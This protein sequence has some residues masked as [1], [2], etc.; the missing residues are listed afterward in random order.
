VTPTFHA[1]AVLSGEEMIPDGAFHPPPSVSFPAASAPRAQPRSLT[2]PPHCVHRR[3]PSV[4]LQ[5]GRAAGLL[6]ACRHVYII[7]VHSV[8]TTH[9][10]LSNYYSPA[11]Q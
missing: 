9:L 2:P 11:T 7:Y 8:T 3:P 1:V 5:R 6:G 4:L 10:P